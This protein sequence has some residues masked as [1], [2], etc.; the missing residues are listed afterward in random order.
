MKA[1]DKLDRAIK[2]I[3]A[4]AYSVSYT[5]GG[6]PLT[7]GVIA[8]SES[9]AIKKFND[10]MKSKGRSEGIKVFG[11]SLGESESTMIKKGKTI[12]R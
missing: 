10:Y 1:T 7:I 3:D 4:T 8:N 2:T 12:I 11:A 6:A 9:E 5:R